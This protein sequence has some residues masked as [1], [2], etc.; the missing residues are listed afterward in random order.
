VSVALPLKGLRLVETATGVAG[1]YAAKLLG[2]LGAIVTKV[3]PAGGDPS[4]RH[5]PFPADRPDPERS[6]LFIHLNGAKELAPPARLPELLDV[7]D[8][9]IIDAALG[10]DADAESH[11]DVDARRAAHPRLVVASFTPFGPDGPYAR[12]R[13]DDITLYALGGPMVQT[14]VL[15]RE[16]LKLAGN[17]IQ[18][19]WGAIGAVATL[20]ALLRAEA[21]GAGARLDIA[22]IDTQLGSIDRQI[23]HLLWKQWTGREVTRAARGAPSLLPS[24]YF[25]CLD[26]YVATVFVAGWLPRLLALLD[27]PE[28][29]ERCARPDWAA[30]PDV[31]GLL[32]AGV[33]GWLAERTRQQAMADGAR[34][35]LPF[36]P[37]NGPGDLHRDPHFRARGFFIER[38]GDLVPRPPLRFHPPPSANLDTGG[39]GQRATAAPAPT[40]AAPRRLQAG[41]LPLAGV[42]VLDLTEVWSGP[43]ATMLLADLGAE[44]IR[45]DNPWFFPTITRGSFARPSREALPTIGQYTGCYPDM[46]PGERPWNRSGN[47]VAHSR[48][49][50]SC[51]LDLR[52]P[53]GHETFLRLVE[54]A[55]VV[56]ENA[57]L[58]VAD[59]LGIGWETLVARNPRL[60]MVRMPSMGLDGPYRDFVGF[61]MHL[62]ALGGTASLSGYRDGD[63]SEKSPVYPMDPAAGTHAALG[64]MAGLRQRD[65][66]GCGVLVEVPQ[67]E[68]ILQHAG[69]LLIE[70]GWR[71]SNPPLPGNRHVTF[72]PQ[73]CY[74]CRGEDRWV[75]LT[76]DDDEAWVGLRRA[77]GDPAWAGAAR[78]DHVDGRRAHHDELDERLSAWTR[79]HDATELFHR[80]QAHGVAAAPVQDQA[81]QLADP[82]LAARGCYRLNSS[83][84]V[85]PTLMP[86]HLWRWDGPPLAWGP[87]NRL[88]DANEEVFRDVL[89]L[90]DAEYAALEADGHLSLDYLAPDGTPL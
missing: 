1:P 47:Y 6:A 41:D 24:G 17:Q 79:Q 52:R 42:R 4:R 87:F 73:G 11:R 78:F 39:P 38:G 10:P 72:A 80:L 27:D 22:G 86:G 32:E 26:G 56:I 49:K 60:V 36:A 90:S 65:R 81:G 68:V 31:P 16:P 44:V 13:A 58:N 82:H 64:A 5:G 21:S 50:K 7:A 28:L 89:G 51:T 62:E 57:S 2:D 77:M 33:Y 43:Y 63:P 25:P 37:F 83:A 59:R 3:E 70:A 76:V 8:A 75:V 14:G 45:V 46:E 9:V 85:P 66:T 40:A 69:E 19:Q 34:H 20:G 55:D 71:G 23:N 74:P 12:Y 30:D 88:G 29:N 84:E 35:R 18:Y 61:G 54:R 48:T 53:L 67:V 15:E